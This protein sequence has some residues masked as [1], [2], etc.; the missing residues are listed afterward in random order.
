MCRAVALEVRLAQQAAM[1]RIDE[2]GLKHLSHTGLIPP[3]AGMQKR[4]HIGEL[5]PLHARAVAMKTDAFQ[6]DQPD[7][8]RRVDDE[9]L[10]LH[11]VVT[12][13]ERDKLLPNG[14]HLL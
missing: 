5:T 13:A 4:S 7:P 10:R 9:I 8:I 6:V 14:H 1:I 2:R 12:D 3:S 11:V